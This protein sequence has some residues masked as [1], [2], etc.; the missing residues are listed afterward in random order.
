MIIEKY[1]AEDMSESWYSYPTPPW[2]TPS[3]TV[4]FAG[5]WDKRRHEVGS[6]VE[7]LHRS[8]KLIEFSWLN[9]ARFRVA[10]YTMPDDGSDRVGSSL[11]VP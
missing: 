3:S 10:Q 11:S 9:L 2:R 4:Q 8:T 6:V 1:N 5:P 7:P